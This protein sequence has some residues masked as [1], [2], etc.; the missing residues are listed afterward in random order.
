MKDYSEFQSEYHLNFWFKLFVAIAALFCLAC[1]IGIAMYLRL[2][3]SKK[4]YRETMGNLQMCEKNL[5]IEAMAVNSNSVPKGRSRFDTGASS[6]SE[7]DYASKDKYTMDEGDDIEDEEK[8]AIPGQNTKIGEFL[9]NDHPDAISPQAINNEPR[10][11]TKH[12][13]GYAAISMTTDIEDIYDEVEQDQEHDIVTK[14]GNTLTGMEME[15][16]LQKVDMKEQNENKDD[17][18]KSQEETRDEG[19]YEEVPMQTPTDAGDE[20]DN[21]IIVLMKGTDG[22]MSV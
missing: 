9:S 8:M 3:R 22:G 14:D 10:R 16:D 19:I 4:R 2:K 6:N 5:K 17:E 18:N 7:Y 13:P 15:K 11:L 20:D 12:G 21:D 1:I